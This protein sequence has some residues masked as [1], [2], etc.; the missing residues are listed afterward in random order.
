MA[1]ADYEYFYHD[2]RDSKGGVV[3]RVRA[4]N[5]GDV[6]LIWQ[7]HEEALEQV[8]A[9]ATGDGA[10]NATAKVI[11]IALTNFP[12]LV[13]DVIC[14]ASG[15]DWDRAIQG[16]RKMPLGLKME[17]LGTIIRMTLESEGGLEKLFGILELM[18]PARSQNQAAA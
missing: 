8:L 2:I 6:S 14:L 13:A 18:R 7:K 11:E 1:F 9:L 5:D 12:D 16:V 17:A 10:A 15:E 3:G 4:L